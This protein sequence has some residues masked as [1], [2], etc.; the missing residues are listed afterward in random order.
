M[1]DLTAAAGVDDLKRLADVLRVRDP[2]GEL[3]AAARELHD[4]LVRATGLDPHAT[5]GA[6]AADIMLPSGK[7]IAP[8]WAASCL[9]DV[10]RTATFLRGT[11]AALHAAL[12][13]FPQRPVEMLYSGCGPFAP[14]ALMLATCFDAAQVRV[15]LLDVNP[16]SLACARRLFET[17]GLADFVRAY[18]Q[19]D[20]TTFVWPRGLP[21]HVVLAETM[22]RALEEEPQVAVSLNLAPQLCD[23]GILIPERIAVDL[24]LY[25]PACGFP[26]ADCADTFKGPRLAVRLGTVL[27]LT[28]ASARTIAVDGE[29]P[30]TLLD[31][32]ADARGLSAMLRTAVTVFGDHSLGEHASGITTPLLLGGIAGARRVRARYAGGPRPGF[33][34]ERMEEA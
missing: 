16:R 8:K 29:Y 10:A 21:L 24:C 30:V 2:A 6:D 12:A 33:R 18:V 15:T 3:P 31:V 5:E 27:E 7:A 19:A 13:R 9:L 14:F 22:Q 1:R 28:A 25:D 17:F 23:G 20:A 4:L 11:E 32:P 26:D 34:C